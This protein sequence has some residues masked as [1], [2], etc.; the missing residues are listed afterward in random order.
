MIGKTSPTGLLVTPMVNDAVL[1]IIP[2]GSAPDGDGKGS[3]AAKSTE[4]IPKK[5]K[6]NNLP[7]SLIVPI[8]AIFP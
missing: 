6:Q 4:I 3:S 7:P 8:Y 5:E 1:V 2:V